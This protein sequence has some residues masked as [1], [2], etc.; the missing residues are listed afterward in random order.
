MGKIFSRFKLFGS[1]AS[2]AQRTAY[3]EKGFDDITKNNHS[4]S[5]MTS[6]TAAKLNE[7]NNFNDFDNLLNV[8]CSPASSVCI[9]GQADYTVQLFD[10]VR[11][12]KIKAWK[13][14]EKDVTKVGL[15]RLVHLANC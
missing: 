7:V 13:G 5:I 15:F 2:K 8:N 4:R 1:A 11:N 14:H 12:K 10:F 6:Q 3:A 9:F